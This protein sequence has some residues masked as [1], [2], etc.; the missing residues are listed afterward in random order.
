MRYEK[1]VRIHGLLSLD[2]DGLHM[3]CLG[4][5]GERRDRPDARSG[6]VDASAD[7]T[8]NLTGR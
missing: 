6:V 2:A 8:S 1:S 7:T 5:S 4:D 3:L